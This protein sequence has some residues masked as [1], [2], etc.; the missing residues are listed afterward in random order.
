LRLPYRVKDFIGVQKNFD[1]ISNKV[2]TTTAI[3]LNT[4]WVNWGS[5]YASLHARR[6]M[7]ICVVSGLITKSIG[8]VGGETVATL[9]EGFRPIM[10]K[11]DIITKGETGMGEMDILTSGEMNFLAGGTAGGAGA[12]GGKYLIVKA[13]FACEK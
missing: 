9:P 7:G 3:S 4:N 2:S 13:V 10:G 6:A 1:Y 11:E 5:G 12:G 8:V